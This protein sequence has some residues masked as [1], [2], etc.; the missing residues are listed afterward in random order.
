MPLAV[1]ISWH[2]RGIFFK[3]HPPPKFENRSGGQ[4]FQIYIPDQKPDY[5]SGDNHFRDHIGAVIGQG[6]EPYGHPFRRVDIPDQ[7]SGQKGTGQAQQNHNTTANDRAFE[8][9]CQICGRL[10]RPK[11]IH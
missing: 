10:G 2:A 8:F 11:T 5:N 9:F 3:R 4:L 6:I 7:D 1:A